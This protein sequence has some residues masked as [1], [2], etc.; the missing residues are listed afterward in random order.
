MSPEQAVTLDQIIQDRQ[1]NRELSLV[2]KTAFVSGGNRDIGAA[3]VKALAA[4]KVTVAFSFRDKQKR[5]NTVLHDVSENNGTAYGLSADMSTSEGR[6]QLFQEAA[7]KL[8]GKVD[9]VVLVTSGS[10]QALNSDASNDL[11]T[12][13]LPIMNDGGVIIRLQSV[14]GHFDPQLRGA[15]SIVSQ[16]DNV[17]RHKYED[18]QSLHKRQAEMAERG[19]RFLEVTPPIVPD[20]AN[21]MVF[22]IAAKRES[23]GQYSAEDMHNVISDKLGLP[24]TVPTSEVGEKVIALLKNPSVPSGYTEFFNDIEDAQTMLEQWYGTQQV[25]VQTMER[26]NQ[27]EDRKS[28]IGRAIATKNQVTRENDQQLVTTVKQKEG[29]PSAYYGVVHVDQ[30]LAEGH[31]APESGLP[32]ILPGHKQIRAAI[33]TIGLISSHLGLGDGNLKL[34]GFREVEFK[35]IVSADGKTVLRV[36]PQLCDDGTY[37]VSIIREHDNKIT[38]SIKG[39]KVKQVTNDE[40]VALLEDQLIEGAAQA[41]GIVHLEK[42]DTN[43]MPLFL[44]IGETDFFDNHTVRAGDGICYDAETVQLDKR[45]FGSNIV[46]SS[47]GTIIGGIKDLQATVVKRS[48]IP[49]L[50]N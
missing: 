9:Y 45:T 2:D 42:I 21:V 29:D 10:T 46:I 40:V 19:I 33:E 31:F 15:I 6:K 34:V 28:G 30:L 47:E 25:Y 27:D 26:N 38:A 37:N 39:L 41:A 35:E 13:F 14:P 23:N 44:R 4:E 50:I 18:L 17:A 3:I 5:A 49:K 32:K 1:I 48:I 11:V 7:E 43:V 22:N 12:Q 24:R 20:T 36:E 16:Y 8:N